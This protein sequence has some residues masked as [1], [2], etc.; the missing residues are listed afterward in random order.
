MRSALLALACVLS[1]PAAALAQS[2]TAPPNADAAR[3]SGTAA[4]G[5]A[6]AAAA[7]APAGNAP[8]E[9]AAPARPATRGEA[10][11]AAVESPRRAQALPITIMGPDTNYA[12]SAG[13]GLEQVLNSGSAPG[14]GKGAGRKVCPPGMENRGDYCGAPLD[15][16]SR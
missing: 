15:V 10:P 6:A 4:A 16:L 13:T 7:N 12:T 3:A 8:L 5:A 14:G 2:A 9:R 11:A 1:L